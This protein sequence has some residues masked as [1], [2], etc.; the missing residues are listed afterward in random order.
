MKLKWIFLQLSAFLIFSIM[1]NQLFAEWDPKSCI[2]QKNVASLNSLE[3]QNFLNLKKQVFDS[4]RD[5][6]CSKEKANLIMELILLNKP[7]VCV[8]IGVFTGSSF[9]PMAAALRFVNQG[10]A[11]AI[12]AWSNSEAIKGIP[13]NDPNYQ[14]WSAVDMQQIYVNFVGTI[15][16]WSLGSYCTNIH[17]PSKEASLQF[18][19][20][21]FLCLDGNFSENGSLEDVMFYLP[22]VSSG[23]YILLSNL[24]ITIGNKLPK[25]KSLW[26]LF[27]QCDLIAEIEQG[28]AV[29][30]QKN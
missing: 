2:K 5:S 16:H 15:D 14:W 17:L 20:I 29:L 25:M 23:G 12:D 6:W 27:D 1:A 9:L 7:K 10:H 8:E 19:R 3:D 28:N 22:K 18:D 11:Y 30:F 26:K 4:L 13:L 24:F 21:D